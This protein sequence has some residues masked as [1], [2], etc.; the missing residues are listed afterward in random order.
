MQQPE[1]QSQSEAWALV[2]MDINMDIGLR[3]SYE[4]TVCGV[5]SLCNTDVCCGVGFT[6]GDDSGIFVNLNLFKLPLC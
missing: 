4:E 2:D 5:D 1:L 3:T 6:P